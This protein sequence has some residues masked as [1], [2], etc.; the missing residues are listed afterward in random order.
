MS[1]KLEKAIDDSSSNNQFFFLFFLL[2]LFLYNPI[3]NFITPQMDAPLSSR[4]RT[5]EERQK[6]SKRSVSRLAL[7]AQCSDDKRARMHDSG[8]VSCD[9]NTNEVYKIKKKCSELVAHL[10]LYKKLAAL[11]YASTEDVLQLLRE[12]EDAILGHSEWKDDIGD[13][14]LNLNHRFGTD[15]KTIFKC[16]LDALSKS[17]DTELP[18]AHCT[19]KRFF[20]T[21]SYS[22]SCEQGRRIS[23]ALGFKVSY[24]TS[25]ASRND[26][27]FASN[28]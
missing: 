21:H 10:S 15:G 13:T 24:G 3:H 7:T 6:L 27:S 2:S 25:S 26:H 23:V 12:I 1:Q 22:L 14:C 19:R 11:R 5:I 28:C 8:A 17:K 9:Q 20:A 18:W 4:R 16:I